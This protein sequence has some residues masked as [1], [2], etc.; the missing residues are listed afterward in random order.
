[1]LLLLRSL[2]IY[3]SHNPY[4]QRWHSQRTD[5]HRTSCSCMMLLLAALDTDLS[6]NSYT[7]RW[8]SQRTGQ[9]HTSCIESYHLRRQ[10]TV[11]LDTWYLKKKRKVKSAKYDR[12]F[13]EKEKKVKVK[14]FKLPNKNGRNIFTYTRHWCLRSGTRRE[15]GRFCRKC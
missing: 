4:T 9:L 1:M 13:K 7:Q 3:P 15:Q 5:L 11:Q 12:E 6:H 2:D 10:R 8:H 14:N